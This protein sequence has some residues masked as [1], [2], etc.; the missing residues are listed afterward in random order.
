MTTHALT[1]LLSEV[2]SIV[3]DF[4]LLKHPFYVAWSDGRLSRDDLKAYACQYMH[5]VLAEPTYISAVHS[6]TPHFA[7]DGSSDLRARQAILRNLMD[8]ELGPSNHPELWKRFAHAL[9]ASERELAQTQPLPATRNLI[10]TFSDICRNRPY[11]AGLS[12]LHAFESQ[13]PQ[14][15]EVKIDGLRRFYGMTNPTEY[16]FFSVH[17]DA[18]VSH[19]AAEW[20]LIERAADTDQR[21]ADVLTATHDAS[22]ALWGFLTGV[23][24]DAGFSDP[25]THQVP[26]A[27]V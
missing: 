6:N 16:E 18:D 12:A 5:H 27:E 8:E 24:E 19:S 10:E 26:A 7:P 17:R 20:E 2:R 13:V 25:S 9:G 23:C 11:Y 1:P 15:A 21:R 22:A 3:A 4:S 14:I